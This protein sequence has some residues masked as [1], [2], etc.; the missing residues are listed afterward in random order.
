MWSNVKV[1]VVILACGAALGD[2]VRT[3]R[4]ERERVRPVEH[5]ESYLGDVILR[6]EQSRVLVLV[7]T[8]LDAGS[9]PDGIVDQWFSLQTAEPLLVP[10]SDHLRSALVVHSEGTLRITT[11]TS[12]YE[13]VVEGHDHEA[14]AHEAA[15]MRLV[16]IGLAH[17]R[18]E[19]GVRLA[20]QL[21][22]AGRVRVTCDDCDPFVQDPS[23]GGGGGGGSCSSGGPGA[24]SCSASY[25]TT[26]CSVA[27]ATGYYACCHAVPGAAYCRCIRG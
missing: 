25:G 20:S 10:L 9:G 21:D 8:I 16:G 26:S 6:T 23:S 24:T 27:C 22:R 18:G 4:A 17:A 7:D 14:R 12:R 2:D 11:P 5:V 13:L 1:A 3:E 15:S 19:S